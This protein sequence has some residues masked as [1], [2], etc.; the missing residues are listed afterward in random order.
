MIGAISCPPPLAYHLVRFFPFCSID[1]GIER[2]VGKSEEKNKNR[3]E[4]D[5]LLRA[6]N[7]PVFVPRSCKEQ[8]STVKSSFSASAVNVPEFVQGKGFGKYETRLRDSS[9][10][11]WI[12]EFVNIKLKQLTEDPGLLDELSV[13][14]ANLLSAYITV[15]DEMRTVS[16]ILFQKVGMVIFKTITS[17]WE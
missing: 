3:I 14:M 1:A 7:Y 12:I 11:L 4:N 15:E 2:T 5:V 8:T 6:V 9:R 17:C 16:N 10:I 13:F